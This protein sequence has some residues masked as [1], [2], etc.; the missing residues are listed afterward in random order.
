L[1]DL[2]VIPEGN[3]SRDRTVSWVMIRREMFMVR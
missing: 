2:R 1:P 3:Q